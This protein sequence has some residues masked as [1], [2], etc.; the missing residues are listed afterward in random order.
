M[1]DTFAT[2]QT[3]ALFI[4]LYMLA[5]GTGILVDHKNYAGVIEEFRSSIAVTYLAGVMTFVLGAVIVAIHNL[6]T[7][8]AAI[9][10]SLVGWAAL[11]EGILLLAFRRPFLDLVSRF[12]MSAR[13]MY[14]FGIL[15]MAVG[16]WLVYSAVA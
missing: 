6:W 10:V 14:P 13:T 11:V 3:F 7:S 4:G 16:V 1:P 9:L 2:T 15:A 5:G 12:P 8:P